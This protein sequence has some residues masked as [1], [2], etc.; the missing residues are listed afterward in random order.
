M[1]SVQAYALNTRGSHS[2]LYSDYMC[3]SH[4]LYFRGRIEAN[5]WQ[6]IKLYLQWIMID[7]QAYSLIRDYAINSGSHFCPVPLRFGYA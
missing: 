7:N 6:G 2:S 1:H 3:K 5:S 4:F